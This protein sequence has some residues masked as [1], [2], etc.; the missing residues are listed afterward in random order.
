MITNKMVTILCVK[1]IRQVTGKSMTTAQRLHSRIKKKY[2]K[3]RDGFVTVD[4]FCAYT[5][6]TVERVWQVLR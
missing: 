3:S 2:N 5:G 4:E 1:D 6:F